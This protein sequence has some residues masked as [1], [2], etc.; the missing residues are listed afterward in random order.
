MF[1]VSYFCTVHMINFSGNRPICSRTIAHAETTTTMHLEL[2]NIACNPQVKWFGQLEEC[3]WCPCLQLTLL[4][5][6]CLACLCIV[7]LMYKHVI[8]SLPYR[9]LSVRD[10]IVG[11]A[12]SWT[13]S[14]LLFVVMFFCVFDQLM[15]KSLDC[16][17]NSYLSLYYGRSMV[18]CN[19][20]DDDIIKVD[21]QVGSDSG[22]ALAPVTSSS[23]VYK[24]DHCGLSIRRTIR[25]STA[26][27]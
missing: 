9:Y 19:A 15:L 7:S 18:V 23:M 11:I 27:W 12:M 22:N 2:L 24:R 26:I 5:S 25:Q 21:N 14:F 8:A 3:S 16:K 13:W 1:I 4:I 10:F 6:Y 20:S 17:P